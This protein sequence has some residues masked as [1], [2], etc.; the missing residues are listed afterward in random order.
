MLEEKR[1]AASAVKTGHH[2]ISIENRSRGTFTGVVDVESFNEECIIAKTELGDLQ[3]QGDGLHISKLNLD[4]N[5]LYITGTVNSFS[6][7]NSV[8]GKKGRI[9]SRVFK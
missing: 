9:I 4:S 8:K 5:E 1:A 3:I 7:G 2:N 6:Y